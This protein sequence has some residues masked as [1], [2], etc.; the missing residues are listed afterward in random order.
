[1]L[2][3]AFCHHLT[4]QLLLAVHGLRS[5]A[6]FHARLRACAPLSMEALLAGTEAMAARASS[7]A[8]AA[9]AAAAPVVT[10]LQARLIRAARNVL[11]SH[12][13][14][15][16]DAIA[17]EARFTDLHLRVD[18]VVPHLALVLEV[19]GPHHAVPLPVAAAA[20]HAAD[21]A[22]QRLDRRDPANQTLATTARAALLEGAGWRVASLPWTLAHA[23]AADGGGR[24]FA[25]CQAAVAA[26]LAPLLETLPRPL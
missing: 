26:H 13:L 16:P 9:V 5:L 22:W 1:M 3:L 25:A 19:S 17:A 23:T 10:P 7:A 24:T 4:Q 2:R 21:S 20:A 6:R 8:G 18:A 11:R 12:G 15:T 14:L